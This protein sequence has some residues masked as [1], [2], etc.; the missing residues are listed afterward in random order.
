MVFFSYE[1]GKLVYE[2]ENHVIQKQKN[3]GLIPAV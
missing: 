1:M 3:R 2:M